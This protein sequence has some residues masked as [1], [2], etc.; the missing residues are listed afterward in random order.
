MSHFSGQRAVERRR[1][2]KPRGVRSNG[3]LYD[4]PGQ[5]VKIQSRR[6]GTRLGSQCQLNLRSVAHLNFTDKKL[7]EEL[8][9]MGSGYLLDFSDSTYAAFFR[10]LGVDIYSEPFS[11]NGHSKAKRMRAFWQV[12]SNMQVATVLEALFDYIVSTKQTGVGFVDNRHWAIA[13]RLSGSPSAASVASTEDEFLA[14]E[15]GSLNVSDLSLDAVIAET[16]DQRLREIGNCVR[17]NASLSCILLAGST[18]EA[19]L[20]SA[21]TSSPADFNRAVAAP[22][23]PVGKVR[24]FQDWSLND[25]INVAHEV[26]RI[27]LD[28]KKF[29]PCASRFSELYPSLRASAVW[30]QSRHLHCTN[31]STGFKGCNCGS[32]GSPIVASCCIGCPST[33]QQA[34]RQFFFSAEHGLLS[35]YIIE[36][37]AVSA[38]PHQLLWLLAMFSG[39][40]TT[41]QQEPSCSCCEHQG[42]L[43]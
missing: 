41:V 4:T 32:F 1:I 26:G 6:L 17:A 25:L 34:S 38:R 19:L 3:W 43:G 39:L 10:D 5:A 29:L 18:L 33:V 31:L 36:S 35:T 40:Q 42:F 21:A 30:I 28:V 2:A 12:A 8:L 22:K 11:I 27:K 24:P 9:G 13:K 23:D 14:T 16:I 15:L 37:V 20:L 7:L